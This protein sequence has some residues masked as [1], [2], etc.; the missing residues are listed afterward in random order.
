MM[1]LCEFIFSLVIYKVVLLLIF[2]VVL[3]RWWAQAAV[4]A[5]KAYKDEELLNNA[6]ATWDSVSR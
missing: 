6:V 4:Y 2:L 3:S 1:M 5:H